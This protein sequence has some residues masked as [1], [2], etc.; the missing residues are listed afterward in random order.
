MATFPSTLL[1]L[2][3]AE[4]TR[5]LVITDTFNAILTE[6]VGAGT[7]SPSRGGLCSCGLS[8]ILALSVRAPL[9]EV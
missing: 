9:I 5:R 6:R 8:T 1:R 7:F 2:V 3:A 4:E